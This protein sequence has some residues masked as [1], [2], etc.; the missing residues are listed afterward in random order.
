MC[1]IFQLDILKAECVPV[2]R[3]QCDTNAS[4]NWWCPYLLQLWKSNKFTWYLQSFITNFLWNIK[5]R[6]LLY[7]N[8]SFCRFYR[9]LHFEEAINLFARL[10]NSKLVAEIKILETVFNNCNK[11]QIKGSLNKEQCGGNFSLAN[12]K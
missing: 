6:K 4:F 7:S 10:I 9:F 12:C 11:S 1:Y 8:N 5:I 2:W 3:G